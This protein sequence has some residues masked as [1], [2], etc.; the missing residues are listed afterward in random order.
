LDKSPVINRKIRLAW[1]STYNSRCGLATHSEHLLEYFDRRF[2]DITVIGD[3]AEPVKPDPP[4]VVRLWPDEAGSLATVREFIRTFDAVF[5]NFHFS[6]MDVHDLAETLRAAR[7][8][9]IDTYLTV[10]KTLDTEIDGRAVS[11]NEIAGVLRGCTRVIVHTA[12]DVARLRS[13]AVVDNVVMIPPGAI[14]RPARDAATV[15]GLLSL[16]QF[17]PIIGTFGFL[18]PPKGLPQL[19]DAFALVLR[20]FPEALLLMLNAEYP[21][22]VESAEERDHCRAL[23]GAPGLED[24]VRLID[25]FL[26]TEEILLLL[27]ACDLAV[28]AYQGSGE[29]DSGA[30]RLGLAAGCP[31]ATTPLAVFANLAGVVHQFSSG[32]AADIAD[33]ILALLRDPLLCA[34]ILRRQQE[35]ISRNSWAAQAARI[36]DIIRAGFEARH[37]VELRPPAPA[38][39]RAQRSTRPSGKNNPDARV[40]DLAERTAA[41]L[42]RLNTPPSP[43]AATP[44]PGHTGRPGAVQF[45]AP[46]ICGMAVEWLPAMKIGRAGERRAGGICAKPGQAGHLVYGPYVKLGAGDYRVHVCWD[47]GPPTRKIPRGQPVATIEAVSRYGKTYLAQRQLRLDDYAGSQH[48][49]RLRIAKRPAPLAIEVRVWTCGA[50]PLTVSSITVERLAPP[51]QELPHSAYGPADI[52]HTGSASGAAGGS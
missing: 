23:I 11:L 5:V 51:S 44:V 27:N 40:R 4:D 24:R 30:V 31:V 9:G 32:S 7:R 42:A 37:R 8:A 52:G 18:L 10:H 29:S 28:F 3:H 13:F 16:Q 43:L 26:E 14:D 50:V 20:H 38:P 17:H 46:E 21:G 1:V 25:E 36:D 12:A 39:H 47:A 34:A 33:G 19:I 49:L 6:L 41:R 48:E 45:A 35:W 22:S 2:Y 15:R